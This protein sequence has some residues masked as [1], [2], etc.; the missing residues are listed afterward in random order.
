MTF[1]L[2]QVV[3]VMGLTYLKTRVTTNKKH[4]IFPKNIKKGTQAQYTRK[5]SNHKRK[6]RE[7]KRTTKSTGRQS[8]KWQ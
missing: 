4:T 3:S 6:E 2:K 5:P 7:G 8:L 1:S